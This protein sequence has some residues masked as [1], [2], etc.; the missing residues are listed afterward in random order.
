MRIKVERIGEIEVLREKYSLTTKC[1]VKMG[2]AEDIIMTA[3]GYEHKHIS[4]L[5]DK[6]EIT[7]ENYKKMKIDLDGVE[8]IRQEMVEA[9]EEFRKQEKV[10][11]EKLARIKRAEGYDKNFLINS[12]LPLLKAE[13]YNIK[14]SCTKEEY[15]NKDSDIY[16]VWNDFVIDHDWN[17]KLRIRN[18]KHYDSEKTTSATKPQSIVKIFKEVVAGVENKI[19]YEAEEKKKKN[20]QRETLENILG[21]PV[22]EKKDWHAYS[23]YHRGRERGCEITYF[24]VKGNDSLRFFSGSVRI[25]NKYINGFQINGLPT[26]ADP[27]KLKKLYELIIS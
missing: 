23:S 24:I 27:I 25:D 21:V 13:G 9:I 7:E 10:E 4:F 18:T 16:L 3:S 17:G 15:I 6:E 8:E 5:I 12:V 19:K 2:E 26:V 1:L 14:I 11:E 22:E 20:S